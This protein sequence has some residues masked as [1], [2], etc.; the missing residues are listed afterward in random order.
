MSFSK[1]SA[2]VVSLFVTPK[3][4]VEWFKRREIPLTLRW[5]DCL[6]GFGFASSCCQLILTSGRF[7]LEPACIQPLCFTNSLLLPIAGSQTLLVE[8]YFS[9]VS[10]IKALSFEI[11]RQQERA[12]SLYVSYFRPRD[13]RSNTLGQRCVC[14]CKSKAG[15]SLEENNIKDE[16]EEYWS[17]QVNREML[18]DILRRGIK[19]GPPLRNFAR[20]RETSQYLSQLRKP[21]LACLTC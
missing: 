16:G 3:V 4:K 20:A 1:Y 15:K 10:K 11:Q 17:W 5:S 9:L 7:G 18:Y 14:L 6:P 8:G 12:L 19:A 21:L 2:S 13:P